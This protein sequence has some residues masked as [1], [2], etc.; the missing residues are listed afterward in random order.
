MELPVR[1][2]IPGEKPVTFASAIVTLEPREL[3]VRSAKPLALRTPVKIES[4]D[5]LWMGEVIAVRQEGQAW[6]ASVRIEHALHDLA[7]LMRL[8]NRFVGKSEPVAV[9]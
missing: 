4:A 2:T 5:R 8:A 1:V 3:S 6:L 9:P 7:D